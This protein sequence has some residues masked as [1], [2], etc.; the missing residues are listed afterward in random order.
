LHKNTFTVEILNDINDINKTQYY[1]NMEP[2]TDTNTDTNLSLII[3]NMDINKNCMNWAKQ[4]EECAKKHPSTIHCS[5]T[6]KPFASCLQLA[7]KQSKC[8]VS[9]GMNCRHRDEHTDYGKYPPSS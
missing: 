9:F 7:A 6:K 5:D 8:N 4:I 3:L 2:N 1:H